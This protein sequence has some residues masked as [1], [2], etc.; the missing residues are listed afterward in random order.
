MISGIKKTQTQRSM[1]TIMTK[2]MNV[3]KL[4]RS[5]EIQKHFCLAPPPPP[6]TSIIIE[7]HVSHLDGGT[8]Q[9]E[10]VSGRN[11]FS[12]QGK[13][14]PR[15]SHHSQASKQTGELQDQVQQRKEMV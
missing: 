6:P 12:S 1:P 15:Q 14:H 9:R 13:R 2:V 8:T 10:G 4:C 5:C 7:V 3:E 11:S